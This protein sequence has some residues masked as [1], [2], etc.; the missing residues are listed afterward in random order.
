MI[1]TVQDLYRKMTCFIGR[2]QSW[3]ACPFFEIDD[4][5]ADQP[6]HASGCRLT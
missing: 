1:V 4:A 3:G 6:E 2:Q 5:D